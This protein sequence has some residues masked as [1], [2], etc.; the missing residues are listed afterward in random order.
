MRI[1]WKDETMRI[2]DRPLAPLGWFLVLIGALAWLIALAGFQESGAQSK[3]PWMMTGLGALAMAGG[4]VAIGHAR[5]LELHLEDGVQITCS[6]LFCPTRVLQRIP[7]EE[8]LYYSLPGE[9]VHP[10]ATPG[11]SNVVDLNHS[12][13]TVGDAFEID[14]VTT[15]M[16]SFSLLRTDNFMVFH[17]TKMWLRERMGLHDLDGY[18]SEERERMFD[19]RT[20]PRY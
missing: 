8:L 9:N 1:E 6:K 19:K 2:T 3:I 7:R 14:L 20:G 11:G 18:A 17:R 5:R 15:G 16:R 13:F 10:P 4:A 12:V